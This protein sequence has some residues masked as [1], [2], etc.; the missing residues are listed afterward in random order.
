MIRCRRRVRITVA[1][2]GVLVIAA[3]GCTDSDEPA[4]PATS[5]APDEPMLVVDVEALPVEEQLTFAA[6]PT[7]GV[8]EDVEV[9]P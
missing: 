3:V 4:G 6:L 1:V 8:E 5:I 9:G 2:L 7:R